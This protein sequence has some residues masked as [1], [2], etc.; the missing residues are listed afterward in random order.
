MKYWIYN[1]I[2][3]L[4]KMLINENI[5]NQLINRFPTNVELSFGKSLQS[6]VQSDLYVIIPRGKKCTLWFTYLNDKMYV[7][8]LK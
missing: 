1:F 5:K 6:K 4:I 7:F 3:K 2:N 8:K